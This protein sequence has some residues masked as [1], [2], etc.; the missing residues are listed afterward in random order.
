MHKLTKVTGVEH[1]DACVE[2]TGVPTADIAACRNCGNTSVAVRSSYVRRLRDLPVLAELPG[3]H[4]VVRRFRCRARDCL[5][6]IFSKPLN[7]LA[8]RYAQRTNRV[9][10][11]LKSV[12]MA[13]TS[14]LGTEPAL[15]LGMRASSS[16]LLRTIS[17]SRPEV[18]AL[19]VLGIYD[20]AMRHGR[21]YGTLLCDL[22][23]GKPVDVLLDRA[24]E[25]VAK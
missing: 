22:E 1:V 25:L 6:V 24:A 7:W 10:Q 14:A 23:S 12:V 5:R 2:I 15:K 17:R 16:T 9:T 8:K 4:A 13:M 19:R 18:P 3:V 11:V 21:T 20:F